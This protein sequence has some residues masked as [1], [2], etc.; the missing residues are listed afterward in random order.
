MY[1]APLHFIR[2]VIAVATLLTS[3]QV[4]AQA[5]GGKSRIAASQFARDSAEI[6]ATIVGETAAF[7]NKDFNTWASEWVHAPYVRVVGWWPKGGVTVREGWDVVSGE[8]RQLMKESPSPNPTANRVRRENINMQIRGNV[9]W[10]TWDEYGLN[11]GDSN[12]DMPGLTRSTRVLEKRDGKW[13]IAYV[14]WLLQGTNKN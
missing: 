10:L 3:I 9:A 14:G 4:H 8:V 7:Y 12:M 1:T 13:R 2:F 6:M 11:T 5:P